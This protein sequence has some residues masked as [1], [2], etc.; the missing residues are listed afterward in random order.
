MLAFELM[1]PTGVPAPPPCVHLV[2][3][4][5]AAA[6]EADAAGGEW[7]ARA[8]PPAARAALR[9]LSALP[10]V[11]LQ[12]LCRTG[13]FLSADTTGEV[14]LST[15]GGCGGGVVPLPAFQAQRTPDGRF[16]LRSRCGILRAAS[17]LRRFACRST[18]KDNSADISEHFTVTLLPWSE[19]G[20][21]GLVLGS[22]YGTV[23]CVEGV[24]GRAQPL[25][26]VQG[27]APGSGV[28]D[29]GA[30]VGAAARGGGE[31]ACAPAVF[32]P[33]FR[34]ALGPLIARGD[35]HASVRA[36]A[37]ALGVPLLRAPPPGE[38]PPP[39]LGGV[40]GNVTR[41]ALEGCGG[42]VVLKVQR[43]DPR[44]VEELLAMQGACSAFWDAGGGG[45]EPLVLPL[46]AAEDSLYSYVVYPHRGPSAASLCPAGGA[47]LPLPAALA[48][49][50]GALAGAALLQA[51]GF[52][53]ADLHAGNVLLRSPA[54]HSGGGGAG[55]ETPAPALVDMGSAVPMRLL[56]GATREYRG[57]P[58]GGRWDSMPPEQ[59]GTG[60]FAAEGNVRMGPSADVFSAGAL[61]ATL[62]RGTP[63]FAPPPGE[64]VT[65]G[66]AR[67]HVGRAG[68]AA[69]AVAA[70]PPPLPPALA[71]W[72]KRALQGA[73]EGRFRDPAEALLELVKAVRGAG[74]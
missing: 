65:A 74:L 2:A 40:R 56:G 41:G 30:L 1:L 73:L 20:G 45:G 29:V 72:L 3:A 13:I 71:A 52:L 51:V 48:A 28:G 70:G 7:V 33:V 57:P 69:A 53:Y 12:P 10:P 24:A 54:A 61:L 14:L 43:W 17:D 4:A 36:L 22:S 18:A 32:C 49:T 9:R 68:G 62:L 26:L 60:R 64:K 5:G 47:P 39:P 25:R 44:V 67:A 55:G 11:A 35:G 50:A 6:A 21:G 46:A 37:A 66:G 63:P 31:G 16:T 23:I 15:R 27:P 38:P 42:A 19:G 8:L 58:R 34:E 59:F